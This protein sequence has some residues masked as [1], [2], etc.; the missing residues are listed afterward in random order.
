MR[1]KIAQSPSRRWKNARRLN[2][3]RTS[4]T[5]KFCSEIASAAKSIW[6]ISFSI[7]CKSIVHIIQPEGRFCRFVRSIFF[8]LQRAHIVLPVVSHIYI[9]KCHISAIVWLSPSTNG[10]P[11][12]TSAAR[13]EKM[14]FWLCLLCLCCMFNWFYTNGKSNRL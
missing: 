2:A 6:S 3:P 8:L 14:P 9:V 1:I 13:G 4:E 10:Q 7:S 11:P 5:G 12:I